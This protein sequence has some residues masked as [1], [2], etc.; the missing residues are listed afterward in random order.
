MGCPANVPTNPLAPVCPTICIW[1]KVT[2]G[3]GSWKNMIRKLW[4]ALIRKLWFGN[5]ENMTRKLEKHDS[6]TGMSA[7]SE[8]GKTW[9]G[10]W[11]ELGI[12]TRSLGEGRLWDWDTLACFFFFFG[13]GE[14]KKW[15]GIVTRS[16]GE[17]RLMEAV[18]LRI[19]LHVKVF[20]GRYKKWLGI[21]TNVFQRWGCEV[22]NIL[23]CKGFEGGKF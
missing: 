16:L 4:W 13:G 14:L 12:V 19:L 8:T 15:L 7:D 1:T 3:F 6:E 11:D 9:F 5:W 20:G 23:A 10:N 18:K 2:R 17:G 21:V 22:E